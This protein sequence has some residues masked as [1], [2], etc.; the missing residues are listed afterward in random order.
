MAFTLLLSIA[1]QNI[2]LHVEGY[3][4][5]FCVLQNLCGP[6]S[7]VGIAT[8]YGLDGPGIKFRWG[9]HF[10]PLQ[11]GP[12]THP[13]SCTMGTGSFPGG[14]YGRG[15]LLTTHPLLAPMSWKSKAITLPTL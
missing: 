3:F 11:S 12:G 2:P 6:D 7:S 10:P 13:A 15:V 4:E 14:K 8:D 5:Y 1:G 9:R